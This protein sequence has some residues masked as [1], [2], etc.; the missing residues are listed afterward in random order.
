MKRGTIWWWDM[1]LKESLESVRI[2]VCFISHSFQLDF[3]LNSIHPL[4]NTILIKRVTCQR[5]GCCPLQFPLSVGDNNSPPQW[6]FISDAP[7]ENRKIKIHNPNLISISSGLHC[8]VPKANSRRCR[9]ITCLRAP[10]I[11][12]RV[13]FTIYSDYF[14]GSH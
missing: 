8:S 13:P 4:Y 3:D 2:N 12:N 7:L 5:T 6:Q 9:I 10:I 1:F 14:Q 11:I